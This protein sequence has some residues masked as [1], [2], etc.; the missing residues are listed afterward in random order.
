MIKNKYMYK[1]FIGYM[2]LQNNSSINGLID[3]GIF[4]AET[5]ENN[6]NKII[7]KETKENKSNSSS[8]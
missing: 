6:K 1:Y 5:N 3:K 4:I 7:R 2:E 8:I